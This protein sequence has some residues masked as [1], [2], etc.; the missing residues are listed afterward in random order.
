MEGKV[1]NIIK[2][3]HGDEQYIYEINAWVTQLCRISIPISEATVKRVEKG[4]RE[5]L[6]SIAENKCWKAMLFDWQLTFKRVLQQIRLLQVEWILTSDWIKLRR[7]HVIHGFYVTCCKTSL[8]Y[9]WVCAACTD[10]IA[11]SRT[12][13]C[14]ATTFYNLQQPDCCKPGLI[15]G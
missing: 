3:N 15:R 11:K 14:S 10:I 2:Q 5:L 1:G 7:S 4:G 13:R 9:S 6:C 12:T 8:P